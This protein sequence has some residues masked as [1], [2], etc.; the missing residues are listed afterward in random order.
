MQMSSVSMKVEEGSAGA[1]ASAQKNLVS[2]KVEEGSAGAVADQADETATSPAPA[3]TPLQ[4]LLAACRD[5]FGGP[6]TAPARADVSL[7]KGILDKIRPED[8]HL[9]AKHKVFEANTDTSG[10]RWHPIITRTTIHKCRNFSIV[11]FFL[12]PGGVIP[13]HNHPGMTVFS[14]LLLGSLHAKSYDWAG[15]PVA[16][17]STPDDHPL[18][19]AKLVLDADLRAPCDALVLY[20][21]SG[22]N[23]HRFAAA[24][25]CAVLDVLGPP[26]SESENRD[27]TYYQDFPYSHHDPSETGDVHVT[28]EQNARL[29]W[30]KETDK[31][32][33]LKMYE[34]PYRGPPIL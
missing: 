33:D 16:G 18:R 15:P 32:K 30:L 12:P 25:A 9:S 19:L 34:V 4:L 21:E 17:G 11:I 28:D 13:L 23:M 14:K 22:G 1:V 8:V 10:R 6:G 3:W 24:T 20:P 29:G 2:M 7:I 31:P 27:C 26:Y 5:A